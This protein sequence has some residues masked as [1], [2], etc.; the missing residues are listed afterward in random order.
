MRDAGL[1][2]VET[3][4]RGD[5]VAPV[6]TTLDARGQ[7][8]TITDADGQVLSYEY[9]LMGR[10]VFARQGSLET[11]HRR[12]DGV[13]RAISVRASGATTCYG[14]DQL[15][16]VV[17]EELGCEE[18]AVPRVPRP[19]RAL[20]TLSRTYTELGQVATETDGIGNV[21]A[22]EYD[23]LGRLVAV[24]VSGRDAA[25]Q[26]KKQFRYDAMGNQTEALDELG[27]AL[28]IAYDDYDRPIVS[29]PPDQKPT[30]TAYTVAS[31][32]WVATTTSPTGE[33]VSTSTDAMGRQVRVCGADGVCIRDVY[34][35]G[36]LASRNRL[37]AG[38]PAPILGTRHYQYHPA[39]ARI[40][41]EWDWITLAE[42]RRCAGTVPD[43]CELPHVEHTYTPAGRAET[44]RD[45]QGNLTTYSYA[46][47][48]MLLARVSRDGLP[49]QSYAY[50]KTYPILG[51]RSLIDPTGDTAAITE[52]TEWDRNL[53]PST[54]VRANG[55]RQETI[56]LG[57]DAA[58]RQTFAQLTQPDG[59]V[60][61]SE[62]FDAYGRPL[63]RAYEVATDQGSYA[64]SLGFSWRENGQLGGVTYP[65]G[66]TVTYHYDKS[67]GHLQSIVAGGAAVFEA[68]RLDASGRALSL[69]LDDGAI[70]V[71][72][73]Y[74]DA[75]REQ[76]RRIDGVASA[77]RLETYGYDDH[78][79]LRTITAIEG[80]AA[81]N[82]VYSYDARDR[83][84]SET[85]TARG[86]ATRS[87][88]YGYDPVT[89]LRTTKSDSDGSTATTTE[90]GYTSGN[91]LASV[92]TTPIAWDGYGRQT[93]DA[94]GRTFRWGLADQLLAIDEGGANLETNWH[95]AAGL[96]VAGTSAG[97]MEFFLAGPGGELLERRAGG[98]A[99]GTVD[100]VRLPGGMVVA[101][102]DEKGAV[103]PVLNGI[104]G[105]PYRIGELSAKDLH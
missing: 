44:F 31:N 57:Y 3:S 35:D 34:R 74:D 94:A 84:T 78:G 96:R 28:R 42:R 7:P 81:T 5:V 97:G 4:T 40:W 47:G 24:K 85:H 79:R 17:T 88:T 105:S 53:R 9:D 51:R 26:G 13:G 95:D 103:T 75:G 20:V 83:L 30:T 1:R 92:G 82:T 91:R 52:D 46:S 64:G 41:R 38:T 54:I 61:I 68:Q 12:Y 37:G 25:A 39:S 87:F 19:P 32:S 99:A 18:K 6:T 45:R 67:T 65:S 49:E 63:S 89:G 77:T 70:E 80:S 90:Y 58:G 23:V 33:V 101:T 60:A 21:V 59:T 72:R 86:G 16:N 76:E 43:D 27:Y 66:N 71:A 8:L 50:D 29:D 100:Y 56:E 73:V 48:S 93:G 2:S 36:L 22:N 98:D 10:L 15:D 69:R 14:Y 104:T 62:T 11:E 102:I 55:G